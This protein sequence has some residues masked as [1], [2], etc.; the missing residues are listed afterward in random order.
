MNTHQDIDFESSNSFV[1]SFNRIFCDW[2]QSKTPY[3]QNGNIKSKTAP[4]W[5]NPAKKFFLSL[6]VVSFI[7]SILFCLSFIIVKYY[8]NKDYDDSNENICIDESKKDFKNAFI[9]IGAVILFVN[10]LMFCFIYSTEYAS[11]KEWSRYLILLTFF[12]LCMLGFNI[13][14]YVVTAKSLKNFNDLKKT[15]IMRKK[16]KSLF[17]ANLAMNF[18]VAICSSIIEIIA[19]IKLLIISKQFFLNKYVPH[20]AVCEDEDIII[21]E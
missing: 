21:I 12:W 15:D 7:C 17:R 20:S 11:D 4:L 3:D 1:R 2:G 10:C 16:C 9:I 8:G 13:A 19:L 6:F 14:Q 18:I 5:A